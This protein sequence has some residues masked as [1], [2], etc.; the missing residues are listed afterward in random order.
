[1][2]NEGL[3]RW[4]PR[5]VHAPTRLPVAH[6]CVTSSSC[7]GPRQA[8]LSVR[9]R[10]GGTN[11]CGS[12]PRCTACT[13]PARNTGEAQIALWFVHP[14]RVVYDHRA[15]EWL[16]GRALE[17][18][19]ALSPAVTSTRGESEFRSSPSFHH[20][21]QTQQSPQPQKSQLST[22]LKAQRGP[23]T[24]LRWSPWDRRGS[25][26]ARAAPHLT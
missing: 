20:C 14:L 19:P 18:H 8:P 17:A 5:R 21:T 15:A 22:V 6:S 24:A 11:V 4:R 10:R 2:S 12:L 13:K 25:A 23:H 26:P 3:N 16:G 7:P 1:M 9:G